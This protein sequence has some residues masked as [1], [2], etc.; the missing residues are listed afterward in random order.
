[1]L[2]AV[3]KLCSSELAVSVSKHAALAFLLPIFWI[4]GERIS[5]LFAVAWY[6]LI[7]FRK[8]A[9]NP[10]GSKLGGFA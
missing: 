10:I 7:R 8:A 5:L 6:A 1:M 2:G 9:E 4:N 3:V